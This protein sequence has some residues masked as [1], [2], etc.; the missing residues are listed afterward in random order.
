M[1]DKSLFDPSSSLCQWN[2]VVPISD[3]SNSN[4]I[5]NINNTASNIDYSCTYKELTGKWNFTAFLI[6]SV[7]VAMFTSPINLLVDFL[8]IDLLSAP[9]ADSLK[10]E[11]LNT[12]QRIAKNVSQAGTEVINAGRRVGRRL[13]QASLQVVNI[14]AK[15][16]GE[17][18][19]TTRSIPQSTLEAQIIASTSA[20]QLVN[21]VQQENDSMRFKRNL[22]RHESSVF[23][24]R[25]T[26]LQKRRSERRAPDY[27]PRGTRSRFFRNETKDKAIEDL[28]TE[29]SVDIVEQRKYLK[30][31]EQEIFDENWGYINFY[32]FIYY[33]FSQI[34]F[35]CL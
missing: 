11:Q 28:F 33:N 34:Y 5:N 14:I 15:S 7:V 30:R 23:K 12:F 35:F 16:T 10:M 4:S 18:L 20:T 25:M 27:E 21:I 9:T 1:K 13:S 6:I 29:L 24:K 26:L 31:S 2:E 32:L 17:D 22:E 8:F 19:S 3:N